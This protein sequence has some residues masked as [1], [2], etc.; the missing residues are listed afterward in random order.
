MVVNRSDVPSGASGAA[1]HAA[2]IEPRR[3]KEEDGSRLLAFLAGVAL[4]FAFVAIAI[5]AISAAVIGVTAM[6]ARLG[7]GGTALPSVDPARALLFAPVV[8]L[9]ALILGALG[10]LLFRRL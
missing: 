2:L 5:L 8:A 7:T 1:R 3:P 6:V 10:V 9:L 4:G